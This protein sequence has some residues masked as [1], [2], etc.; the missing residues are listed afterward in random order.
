MTRMLDHLPVDFLKYREFREL[1][2]T[3]SVD[4]D[5]IDQ[6]LLLIENDQFIMSSSESAVLRR[7]L[8]FNILADRKNETL[9]FRKKRLLVRMQSKPPY[10]LAY[11]RNLLS[12]LLGP[13]RSIVEL[14]HI[15]FEMEVLVHVEST[16]Y[17]DEVVKILERIVPLNIDL[18]SAVLLIQE[19]L[20][21]RSAHYGFANIYKRTNRFGT[22]AVKG[23]GRLLEDATLGSATYPFVFEYKRTNKFRTPTVG[24][25]GL[26]TQGANLGSDAYC[27]NA[28]LPRAN[29]FRTPTVAGAV[30]SE[31]YVNTLS[32]VY[33]FDVG[34]PRTGK[35]IA[36]SG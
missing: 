23:S 32:G 10:V 12:E 4:L 21:L 27:F 24:G 16:S 2:S 29:K 34:L 25:S 30:T 11:L 33:S 9:D 5:S 26:L 36:R 13:N 19:Y 3:V 28:G 22:A 15:L 35:M 1:S 14:D 31:I 8:E 17:Y 7:E 6:N 20:V 18:T